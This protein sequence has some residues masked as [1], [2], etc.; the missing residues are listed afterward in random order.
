MGSK[1]KFLLGASVA[2][3]L[4]EC[5][6]NK[7]LAQ[8]QTI[9]K[10]YGEVGVTSN[11]IDRGLTQSNTAPSVKAGLGYWFGTQGRIGF[12]AHSVNYVNERTSV[13]LRAFGEFKFSF[14]PTSD[15]RIINNLVRYFPED[16]RNRVM[17]GLDQNFS[18]YHFL[19]SGED[20]FE[21]TNK[22]RNWFAIHKDWPYGSS[23]QINT[24]LGYS[25]VE[26][27]EAYFDSRLGFSYLTSNVTT[28]LF[29]TWTSKPDQFEGRGDM[30]F[31]LSILAKF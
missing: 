23:Y 3:I 6:L 4:F 16:D 20:N 10:M 31:L 29:H 28:S 7:A 11:Y 19:V 17:I 8:T 30:A 21:G 25:M 26:G 1:T 18:G 27:F 22:L 5:N 9:S 13:E 15:L 12:D 2:L 24:T 14:S